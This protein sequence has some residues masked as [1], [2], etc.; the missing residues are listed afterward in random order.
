MC[1]LPFQWTVGG[2]SF[3]IK[4]ILQSKANPFDSTATVS[5]S[6]VSINKGFYINLLLFN[7]CITF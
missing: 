7:S 1:I 2:Q 4:Q 6:K 3:E 5:S